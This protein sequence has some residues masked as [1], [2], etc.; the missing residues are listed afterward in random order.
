MASLVIVSLSNLLSTETED[1]KENEGASREHLA[2]AIILLK[3][4]ADKNYIFDQLDH[5]LETYFDL[6]PDIHVFYCPPK[7]TST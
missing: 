5:I 1:E 2:V 4:V 7:K 3:V 6:V